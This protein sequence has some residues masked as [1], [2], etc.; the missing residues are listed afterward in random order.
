MVYV[1]D[2]YNSSISKFGRMKMSHMVADTS[3]ELLEMATKIG[4]Q[5]KWIQFPGTPRE[6]FDICLSKR[7]K[8]LLNGAKEIT[9]R[10][11]SEF[12][13]ARLQ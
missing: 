1:D 11:Y 9:W 6:H 7:K 8:A 3:E 2:M 12:I 5:H 13:M 4:V 10:E